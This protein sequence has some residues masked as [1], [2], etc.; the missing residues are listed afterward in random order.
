MTGC[1][2]RKSHISSKRHMICISSNN[3]RRPVT[4][5]FTPLHYTSRHFT[6]SHL[7]FTQPHFTTLSFGLTPFQ[8]PTVPFHLSSL[9][10]YEGCS[11][12]LY[13][14]QSPAMCAPLSLVQFT[15]DQA[16]VEQVFPRQLLFSSAMRGC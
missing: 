9:L 12:R 15:V 10:S 4:K 2:R 1:D 3:D 16:A 11:L 5:T 6:S 14:I 7:N 13:K 8:F